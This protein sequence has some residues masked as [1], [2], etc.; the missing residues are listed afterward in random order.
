LISL[1]ETVIDETRLELRT[2]AR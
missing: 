2:I 1:K